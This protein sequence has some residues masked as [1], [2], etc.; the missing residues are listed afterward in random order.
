MNLISKIKETPQKELMAILELSRPLISAIQS[1]KRELTIQQKEKLESYFSSLASL[2]NVRIHIP[3]KN[4]EKFKQVLLYVLNKVGAKPNVGQT[5][6]YKLLYF[7]D[8]DYYEKYE[9]QLMGLTY[10][11]NTFGPTPKEFKSVV[12]EM[13]DQGEIDAVRAK[14]F[15][16]KQKKY[17]PV[18]EPDLSQFTAQEVAMIDSVLSRYSDFSATKLSDLSHEDTPWQ[19]AKDKENIDY[20]FAF[21]RPERFS[22]REYS[23]L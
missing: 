23:A 15:D 4:I 20:E 2:E 10:M 21:Y 5:V 6:I 12:D 17:L 8:F 3:Q 19:M 1:G 9:K 18:V 16:H 11:K 7:I 14:H 22:V 13:I